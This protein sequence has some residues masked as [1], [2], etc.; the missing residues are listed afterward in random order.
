MTDQEASALWNEIVVL[1][2]TAFRQAAN[3]GT[4][5]RDVS[6]ALAE[7]VLSLDNYRREHAA[8]EEEDDGE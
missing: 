8:G 6:G 5:D 4:P 1:A 3:G 7:R 2:N